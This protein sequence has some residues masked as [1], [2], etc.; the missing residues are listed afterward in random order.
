MSSLPARPAVVTLP[1]LI[2]LFSLLGLGLVLRLYAFDFP[3]GFFFDEYHFVENARN[4]LEHKADWNDHPPLGKLIIA[5]SIRLL[6]DRAVAWRLPSLVAGLFTVVLAGLTVARLFRSRNAGVVA[7]ALLASD[8]FLISYSRVGV[9]DGML[10]AALVLALFLTTLKWT[11]RLAIAAGVVLGGAACLKFS[12]I[13]VALPLLVS[14]ALDESSWRR[15]AALAVNLG[16]VAAVVYLGVYA[17]GLSLAGQPTGVV[18]VV[19]DSQRLLQ[20]HA[21]LTE[22]KNPFVSGWATWF[23]PRRA[24]VMSRVDT[25]GEARVLTMLGNLATWWSAGLVGASVLWTV[26]VQGFAVVRHESIGEDASPL[27][28]FVVGHGKAV[29]VLTSAAF[30][31]LAPW[32]LSHRDSYLYHFLPSYLAMVMLLGGAIGWLRLRAPRL[33]LGFLCVVLVV[34]AFYAPV[35][36][37]MPMRASA[38]KS[39]LFLEG[40]R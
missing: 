2:A 3:A 8:G 31:F 18:A 17:L 36:S 38:V 12:G 7:A 26:L 11:P 20:H 24:I 25:L 35:W 34:A 39:R 22:M 29:L 4:Y 5:G 16:A 32:M 6:G 23:L 1:W 40:W 30:A 10:A 14:L 15:R 21:A 19:Q 27:A 28:R 13:C 33:A 37:S 9:L